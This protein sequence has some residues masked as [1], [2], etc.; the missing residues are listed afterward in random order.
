MRNLFPIPKSRMWPDP[1]FAQTLLLHCR[2]TYAESDNAPA[3]KEGLAMRDYSL[4]PLIF[5]IRS[6]ARPLK[7]ANKLKTRIWMVC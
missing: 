7:I 3:R 6:C 2:G 5:L 1:I 4:L